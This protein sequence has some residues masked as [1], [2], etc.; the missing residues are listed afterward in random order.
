[1]ALSA[2]QKFE[3]EI[4]KLLEKIIKTNRIYS[5]RNEQIELF[6]S[7]LF[8]NLVGYFEAY[9]DLVLIILPGAYA[10]FDNE[11]LYEDEQASTS[12]VYTLYRS[13][14]RNIA[15]MPGLT[16]HELS[17]YVSIV[18]HGIS[19]SNDIVTQLWEADFKGIKYHKIETFFEADVEQDLQFSQY[20]NWLK[21]KQIPLP[22]GVG[23][24]LFQSAL[25]I[26]TLDY[27]DSDIDSD[28]NFFVD[29]TKNE[30]TVENNLQLFNEL[31]EKQDELRISKNDLDYIKN[32]M[33]FDSKEVIER[34]SDMVVSLLVHFL[35]ENRFSQYINYIFH[36]LDYYLDKQVYKPFFLIFYKL[37]VAYESSLQKDRMAEVLKAIYKE[38][39]DDIRISKIIKYLPSLTEENFVDFKLFLGQ[40][41]KIALV[42]LVDHFVKIPNSEIRKDLIEF[43]KGM[44]FDVSSYYIASLKDGDKDGV[45]EAL[46]Y[47]SSLNIRQEQKIPFYKLAMIH[48]DPEIVSKLFELLNG[49]YDNDMSIYLFN[50]LKNVNRIVLKS[51]IVYLDYLKNEALV[52]KALKFIETEH[53]LAWDLQFKRDYLAIL[54]YKIGSPIKNYLILLFDD[55]NLKVK[56]K[57]NELQLAILYALGFLIEADVVKFLQSI[58]SKLMISKEL[59]IEA[60]KTLERM[61]ANAR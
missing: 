50:N 18:S 42:K 13:G 24:N 56:R 5:G 47:I 52:L 34:W 28:K 61:K 51:I 41:N 16:S 46:T 33:Y 2:K 55:K 37:K 12:L 53:F 44:N 29:E 3:L 4:I 25:K 40:L 57:F 60:T 39:L 30:I 8:K 1:M 20:E 54:T 36:Y 23:A 35:S 11:V 6:K 58:S 48:S 22:K 10:S 32:Q 14:I 49:Y 15:F 19:K 7:E 38:L 26:T 43:L 17:T 27:S 21:R 31:S 59:K 45:L 9:G